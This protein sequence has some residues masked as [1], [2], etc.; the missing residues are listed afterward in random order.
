MSCISIVCSF[1]LTAYLTPPPPPRHNVDDL[2]RFYDRYLK[3]IDNRWEEETPKVR[4][5]MI[6]FTGKDVVERPEL[7]VKGDVDKGYIF[8]LT[9]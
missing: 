5:S 2:Q 9:L 7:E 4:L 6:A 8:Q 3:N 1:Q